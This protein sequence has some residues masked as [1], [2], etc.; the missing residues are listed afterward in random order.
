MPKCYLVLLHLI[1]SRQNVYLIP[2]YKQQIRR[3]SISIAHRNV[4][5]SPKSIQWD[6]KANTVRWKTI[7]NIFPD[8]C[9]CW[10]FSIGLKYRNFDTLYPHTCNNRIC[11]SIITMNL[12]AKI[13]HKN[14][15]FPYSKYS[16]LRLVSHL[17]GIQ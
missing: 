1:N 12:K 8:V 17:N 15:I 9:V 4:E 6:P 14:I 11:I 10:E 3:Y 16:K 13:Y 7:C 2:T 5:V